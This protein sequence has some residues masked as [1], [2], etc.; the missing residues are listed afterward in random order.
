MIPQLPATEAGTNT[1]WQVFATKTHVRWQT[2]SMLPLLRKKAS[3]TSTW[4][5]WKELTHP[6]TCG[7]GQL[8]HS[9]T[10]MF[11]FEPS[12]KA[13]SVLMTFDDFWW[14]IHPFT[15]SPGLRWNCPR[16]TCKRW[17]RSISTSSTGPLQ[18]SIVASND[19]PRW[20]RCWSGPNPLPKGLLFFCCTSHRTPNPL[21]LYIYV[22][23]FDMYIQYIRNI[24]KRYEWEIDMNW[25][26][27]IRMRK[28]AMKEGPKSCPKLVSIKKKTDRREATRE[29]KAET[30]A[31]VDLAIER[32]LLERLKQGT[33]GETPRPNEFLNKDGCQVVIMS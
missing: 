5:Q 17:S 6:K 3:T 21:I 16:I 2:V 18:W 25:C 9:T 32:E 22:C 7:K 23:V 11:Y 14:L 8:G 19:S 24:E 10:L 1:T 27:G 12:F 29:L 4:K 15:G 33:Y 20:D 30:A 31:K 28:L 26:G 13:Q